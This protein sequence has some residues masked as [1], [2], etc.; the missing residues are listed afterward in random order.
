MTH[1]VIVISFQNHLRF[2]MQGPDSL[3]GHHFS[4]FKGI[5]NILWFWILTNV[6]TS[7]PRLI[8]DRKII[9]SVDRCFLT[10]RN[11]KHATRGH[12]TCSENAKMIF[13]RGSAPDPAGGAHDAL[14][15][16]LVGWGKGYPL[17]IPH[18]SRCLFFDF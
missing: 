17:P 7:E 13:R 11:G 1:R 10:G 18:P 14:P 9:F 5:V 8:D 16:P 4:V 15:D 2:C 6:L 12:Q 3:S